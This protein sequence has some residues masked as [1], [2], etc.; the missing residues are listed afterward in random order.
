MIDLITEY[1]RG[2]KALERMKPNITDPNE[3][4]IVNEMIADMDYAIDWMRSGERPNFTGRGI[5]QKNA[6]ARRSLINMDLFPSLEVEPS[7]EINN[8]RKKAVMQILMMLTE[9][10]MNCFLLHTAHLRS[11]QE[12]A[13]E[14]GIKK[15]T[16]QEHIETARLK[17][18]E[19]TKEVI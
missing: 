9:R 15:R 1:K 18:T 10:Q 7:K 2:K 8:E 3:L 17:I 6:Y 4:K 14:L 11:M 13:D 12:I 19:L 16:V 5:K